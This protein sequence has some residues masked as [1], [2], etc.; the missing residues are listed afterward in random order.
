MYT[1]PAALKKIPASAT[2]IVRKKKRLGLRANPGER[3]IMVNPVPFSDAQR[4][5]LMSWAAVQTLGLGVS[6]TDHGE[7]PELAVIYRQNP[8]VVL[9]K[10]HATDNGSV[11]LTGSP[12][13]WTLRSIEAALDV[14]SK[15]GETNAL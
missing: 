15:A 10:L 7:V 1:G 12:G 11:V 8:K 2:S 13:T 14:I 9:W 3:K 5:T 6:I 4:A